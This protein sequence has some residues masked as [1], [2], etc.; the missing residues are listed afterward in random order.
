[1][2]AGLLAGRAWASAVR[3]G[4]ARDRPAFRTSP[5]YTQGLH[6]L[7]AGQFELAVSE[8]TKVSRE[9]PAAPEVMLVLGNLLRET[10]QVER[11]IQVH[12]KLLARGDL[13][14]AEQIHAR[15]C[16]GMDFRKA[17]FLDRAAET[18]TDVLNLDPKNV[19]A[20]TGMLKLHE[21]QR[22]W[23]DAYELQTRLSRLRR[24]DDSVVLGFLQA[25]LGEEAVRAGQLEAAE[26]AFRTALSL[27]A[28]VFPAHLGLADLALPH[29]PARACQLLETAIQAAP[30][31]AYL[32]FSRLEG[33][34]ARS[35]EPSR[36]VALCER[37]IAADP[38][39]WRARLALAR[40]LAGEGRLDESFGLLMRAMESNPQVLMVHLEAWR[41]LR[42][43]GVRGPE[44]DRYV[45][46]ADAAVFYRDPHVCT[47]CRYRADDMQ[48]RCPHCHEWNT[49]VEERLAA[50]GGG[51]A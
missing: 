44:L 42:A 7:T 49:F 47:A 23:R 25:K 33:A 16:L 39:D 35:G 17:G 27:D 45:A 41:T 6:Y 37:L 34:Y 15:A 46:T 1:M 40:H 38:H 20:L 10:G 32:A 11:A 31:R 22:Q 3:R 2:I 19:H 24:T 43:L 36:F 50:A 30:E 29:A 51:R 28:R 4:D 13:T 8:L 12:Q 21:E 9:D 5:H 18:F 26:K 14:R 48:W